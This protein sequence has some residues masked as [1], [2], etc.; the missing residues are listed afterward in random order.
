MRR[1]GLKHIAAAAISCHAVVAI[2]QDEL[3]IYAFQDG[4]PASGLTA[5]LDGEARAEIGA[6][7]SVMFDLPAGSHSVVFSDQ[8]TPVQTIRFNSAK[9]QYVDIN[10]A[11]KPGAEAQVS[12]EPYFGAET[13]VET[14]KAPKGSLGGRI[15][16]NGVP[17]AGATI[18]VRGTGAT[19]TTDANGRY[20]L[21]LPRGVYELE[22]NHDGFAAPMAEDV[23]V[24]SGVSRNENIRLG[25]STSS[26]QDASLEEIVVTAK[27][28]PNAFEESERFAVN[29]IDTIG[30]EE[31]ARFG[32]TDVAASVVRVPSVTIQDDKYVFIRGLGGRYI[33]T[34]L[35]GSTL[36]STDPS[37]RTVPLDLFPTNMVSQL[38]VKKTFVASMPGE[39]TG[40]NLVINT[41]SFP[42]ERAGKV[43]FSL[44]YVPGLTGDDVAADPSR[45][46]TDFLGW[47]GGSRDVP[48]AVP[49]IAEVLKY[50]DEYSQNVETELRQ[51][52]GLLLK[53]DLD[54]D[55]TTATPKVSLGL[56][57][58]D[59]FD[60]D[61][62]EF[63]YFAAGNYRN[64]WSQKDSGV[65]RTYTA[66]SG[67]V[68]DDFTFEEATN[69][70]DASALLALGLN[71]GSNTYQSNSLVSRVTESKTRVSQGLDGDSN[72][73]SYR[74]TIDWIERQFL[75]QQ[76]SGEHVIGDSGKLVADWQVTGSQARRYAPDRREVRFD[77]REGDGVYNL[78]V[79]NLLRRYDDL[80]DNNVDVSSDIEYS[81]D[82]N[83]FGSSKIQFGVQVIRR[84]RDAD[85]ESYGYDGGLQSGVDDN[86]P[87]LLVS[88]VLTVDNITGDS[89]TGFAFQD[90][91]LPSDSYEADMDLDSVYLSYDLMFLDSYQIVVGGRYEDYTQTTDTFELAGDQDAASSLLDEGTFLPSFSFNW[92]VSEDQQ[93]RFAVSKTVSR[94]DFKETSNAV[95]YDKEFD[96]RVRGNPNLKLSE[97][98]NVDLRWERYFSDTESLSVALFYK[99]LK[100][101][102]ERV[103]QPASGTAG[104]SRTFSNAD[105]AELYGI[106][107]DLR[108]DFSFDERYDRTFFIAFNGSYI[109]S[110]VTLTTGE[111]RKLQGQPDYTLNVVLGYDDL[112]TRQQLTLLLNQSGD[113][114][115]DVGVSGRPDVIEEP[116]LAL[117]VNY[118]FDVTADF[119]LKAKVKNLLDSEVEFTQGGKVF[120][121]YD[122]GMELEAGFDWNF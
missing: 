102:I 81:F 111:K 113:N 47:D 6:D 122:K 77:L 103:V 91:T 56:N 114:I 21:E 61:G 87:N 117:D 52:G 58:G 100:D 32:D 4:K 11:L 57:Y 68:F 63:G 104:N 71:M 62:N 53:D 74:Y 34:T 94:P 98:V 76:F 69:N 44:G 37:K 1:F 27:L 83:R 50:D 97:V 35:N 109:D 19:A 90:K 89:G 41:R 45:S 49:S 55:T 93:L 36:P 12:V 20:S 42:L 86:A 75:S 73:Q 112:P 17:L 65:S 82:P 72:F 14:A 51:I 18:T 84:E 13:A 33:T 80:V 30:I 46:D 116:R 60:F 78:Q 119:A 79:P 121:S 43:S 3:V 31:L 106:E 108:K 85:S 23:R 92:F 67:E 95:F 16:N 8:G 9:G 26:S 22:I 118:K 105:S 101:P 24:V 2:A 28:Q 96:F 70:I 10:V 64:G 54:L 48:A 29:V 40:G 59:V 107:L 38:D 88:E 120:Q 7:G 39:S 5:V 115:V 15:T 25:G 99:D 66:G 110:E